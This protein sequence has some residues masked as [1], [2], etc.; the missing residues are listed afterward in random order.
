MRRGDLIVRQFRSERDPDRAD[1]CGQ[2]QLP[3]ID[4][5]VPARLGP[6]GLGIDRAMRHH[7]RLAVLLVPDAPAGAQHGTVDRGGPRGGQ[8]RLQLGHQIAP[9]AADLRRQRRREGGEA[10][11]KR[12]PTGQAVLLQQQ[13]AQRLHLRRRL[14][15]HAEQFIGRGQVTHNHD[16]QGLE[17]EAVRVD[18]RSA[19]QAREGRRGQ[20]ETIHQADQHDKHT[21]LQYHES[22]SVLARPINTLY[23]TEVAARGYPSR[24]L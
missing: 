15:Q 19:P 3:A 10:A 18:A 4:P 23:G 7:P 1:D 5:A 14:G 8:P 22:T 6:T 9:Q 2:M 20:R 11:L 21:L 16:D 12:A 13:D 17:K 24:G